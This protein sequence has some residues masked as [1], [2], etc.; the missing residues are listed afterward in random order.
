MNSAI[1]SISYPVSG[2]CQCGQVRLQPLSAPK[3]VVA[4]HCRECQKL[5]TSA[6]SITALVNANQVLITG[7]LQ[8]WERL[9]ASGNRNCAK[10]CPG[11]GNRIYHYNPA[12][13]A[14]LKLK[15]CYLENT[16]MLVPQM[17]LWV[18]EKQPWL[19]LPEGVV[20]FAQQPEQ[21]PLVP[22]N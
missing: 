22:Q 7:E 16:A 14:Q 4:C 6:F 19:Q 18:S 9:A 15:A 2:S 1:D 10:F 11:C 13:P 3:L 20:Q 12:T 8:H 21:L 5:S 17:H